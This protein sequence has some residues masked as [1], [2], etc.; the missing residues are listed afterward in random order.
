MYKKVAN[1]YYSMFYQCYKLNSV[2]C[3]ATDIS[4]TSCTSYWL[5]DA[6]RDVTGTKTFTAANSSV[7]WLSGSNN[8]IPSGWTRVNAE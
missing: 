6:G 4:A 5:S 8:G 7:N 3:L 2:T 1:C